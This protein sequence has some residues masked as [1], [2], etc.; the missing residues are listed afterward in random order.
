MRKDVEAIMRESWANTDTILLGRKTWEFSKAMG[1]GGEMPGVKVKSYVFSRTLKSIAEKDTERVTSEPADF[2]RKP[3][4]EPGRD[5]IV[6]SGGNFATTVLKE[7][8]IDEKG[9]H[10]HPIL[11]GGGV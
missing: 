1:G 6:R 10:V 3:K 4:A 8:V 9:L 11:V 2:V 7:G 5:I